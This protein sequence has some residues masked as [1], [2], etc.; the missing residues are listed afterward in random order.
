[1]AIP[2]TFSFPA[3]DTDGIALTQTVAAGADIVINGVLLDTALTANGV[4]QVTLPG[5]QRRVSITSTGGGNL[6]T[7]L[8]K[9]WGYDLLGSSISGTVTGPASTTTE[10][11]VEFY[12]ITRLT[13][14][15]AAVAS[16]VEVGTGTVGKTNWWGADRNTVPGNY[17]LNVA[18]IGGTINFTGQNTYDD[19]T[20]TTAT[21]TTITV[22]GISAQTTSLSL[23]F[24][25]VPG[26]IRLVV[27]SSA[28]TGAL[29]FT[30]VQ[31]SRY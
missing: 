21:P 16:A 9:V 1:M 22:T 31:Q 6:S 19:V 25:N 29:S 12:K 2:V 5:I 23:P 13:T 8:F 7:I 20:T 11:T 4:R 28:N 24:T 17:N 18:V 30:I 10:T 15:S 26:A 27:N 14:G 3:A